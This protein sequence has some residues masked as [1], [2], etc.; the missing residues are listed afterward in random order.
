[1][2]P[3]APVLQAYSLPLSHHGSPEMYSWNGNLAVFQSSTDC[4]GRHKIDN[5]GITLFETSNMNP[6]SLDLRDNGNPLNLLRRGMLH[7]VNIE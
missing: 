4:T 3:A 2:S 5:V 1:M 6:R 7:R